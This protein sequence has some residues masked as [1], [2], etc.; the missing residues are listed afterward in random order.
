MPLFDLVCIR[1][2]TGT[3]GSAGKGDGIG[4]V[5]DIGKDE[6]GL[7]VEGVEE[8]VCGRVESC[9]GVS[10]E[11]EEFVRRKLVVAEVSGTC[12]KGVV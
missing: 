8:V 12:G 6:F 3:V 7:E 5:E 9:G 11:A 2:W 1:C 4:K 10:I